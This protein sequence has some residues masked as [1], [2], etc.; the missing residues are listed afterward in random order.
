MEDIDR[1]KIELPLDVIGWVELYKKAQSDIKVM[2][3]KANAAKAKIQE[4]LG[5]NEIGLFLGK[6][7]VRWTRVSTTRLDIAKAKEVLNPEIYAYLSRESESRRF[8]V[9]ASDDAN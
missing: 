2:E 3:E 8:T 5:D 1:P 7:L 9:V 6:P 4:A